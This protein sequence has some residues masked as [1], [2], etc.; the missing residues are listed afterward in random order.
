M[1][2]Y[3]FVRGEFFQLGLAGKFNILS[4]L[5][6]KSKRNRVEPYLRGEYQFFIR[7]TRRFGQRRIGQIY[8]YKYHVISIG[9][10]MH[11]EL[12]ERYSINVEGMLFGF[13]DFRIGIGRK[14]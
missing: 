13:N 3:T 6:V 11:C 7:N 1:L 5:N 9:A 10:G 8:P 4:F 12:N 14:F 2:G